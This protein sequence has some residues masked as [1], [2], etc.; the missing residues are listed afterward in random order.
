[1]IKSVLLSSSQNYGKKLLKTVKNFIKPYKK[2]I[3]NK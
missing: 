1:M 3:L 2:T